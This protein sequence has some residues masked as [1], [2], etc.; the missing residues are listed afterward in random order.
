M[1]RR[2]FVKY[3]AVAGASLM[4]NPF[5]AFSFTNDK[6]IKLALVGTGHRGS[7]FWGS[8]LLKSF[9]DNVEFVGLCDI[10]PGRVAYVKKVMDVSC[11]VFTNFEE[12]LQQ[13]K[14][15][16]VIVTTVDAEHDKQIVTALE[17][18]F[19]V[20]TEKPM[21]TDEDKCR[22]I[23]DAE[24]RTG[25]KVIVAF[26]YRHSVHSM[27]IK[28]LLSANRVGKITSVDFN[29]YLNVHHGADYFRRWH[30]RKARSG[31]LWVHKAT[32]HFDLL[33]WWLNSEPVEVMAYGSLDHYGKNHAFRST[34]CRGCEFKD[35]CKFYWD[36]TKDER[37]YNLYAKNE[38]YDGYLRDGCVWSNEIDIYDKMS[39]QIIYANGV[40]VN[41]SLSTYSPYE[42]W[43]IA[44]NGMEGRLE[45]WEDIP[46]L[47][48]TPDDQ[49]K[50]HAIE[51]SNADDAI[52]GEV[53]EIMVMDNF[54]ENY[55]IYT[56]PKIKGGHGGGDIRLQK[57]I[58]TNTNDNPHH[59]MAGTRDGAMS[60][61]IGI[62]ARKS[63][64]LKRPVKITELTDLVPMANR[65]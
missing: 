33:N 44:F 4:L 16:Y 27:Q 42:G 50:R 46:Y 22:R 47:Q 12:M 7:G 23:L 30:G 34:K 40:T 59:V 61:L 3:T 14:P 21:T 19:N 5:E 11:P 38:Q 45:S 51:M 29:W 65:F 60:I 20:I 15:D 31:S 2:K 56:T 64:E 63:I 37:L 55:E 28:E 49:S 35:Q 6:K 24:K 54:K 9:K 53:R 41:Y 52:P 43:Q 26:N 62:A 32:H 10:N 1:E 8:Q 25:K 58:F 57:R 48:K 39:A 18:G 17:M 13:V 36:I